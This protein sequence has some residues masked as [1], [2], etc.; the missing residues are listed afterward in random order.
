MASVVDVFPDCWPVL[1][2]VGDHTREEGGGV[3]GRCCLRLLQQTEDTGKQERHGET[4]AIQACLRQL[5][6][7]KG[8]CPL[9]SRTGHVR[10]G[11]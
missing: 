4:R 5:L 6:G 2:H 7:N 10:V 11:V 3:R 9:Y 8:D 1:T